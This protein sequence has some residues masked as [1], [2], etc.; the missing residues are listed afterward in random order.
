MPFYKLV[1]GKILTALENIVLGL[2]MT[3][4]HS[5]YIF[6]SRRAINEIPFDTLS[7]YFE[8]D[9]EVIVCA[10]KRWMNIDELAIPTRY[11]G[12]KSYLNP[13]VYGLR[14]LLVLYK[15]L[16]GAYSASTKV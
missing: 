2:S 3:D 1:G 7:R 9:F 4:F 16:R 5:G 10:R 14:V 8:F 11:A 15:S 13:V 6:Y 12:E